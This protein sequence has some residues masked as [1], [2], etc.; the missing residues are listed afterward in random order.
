MAKKS[1]LKLTVV[2]SA[3]M[4]AGCSN[5]L[6]YGSYTVPDTGGSLTITG[7]DAAYSGNG[8][9][10]HASGQENKDYY[11]AGSDLVLSNSHYVEV[12]AEIGSDGGVTLRV[13]REGSRPNYFPVSFDGNATIM[14]HLYLSGPGIPRPLWFGDV[15]A[16]LKNGKGTAVAPAVNITPNP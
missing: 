6:G 1:F 2:C 8:Y 7:F 3:L 4:L 9:A 15:T 5:F 10:I 14:F 13:W 12:P 11:F 16:T